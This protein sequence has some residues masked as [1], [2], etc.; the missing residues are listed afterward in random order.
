MAKG[1]LGKK[2]GMTQI[3]DEEGQAIPVTVIEAKPNVVVQ[4]KTVEI[5]GYNAIQIGFEDIKEHKLNKPLLGHFKKVGVSP[6]RYLKEIRTE[7]VEKYEVGQE[8]KVDIFKKGE[9]VDVVGTS[10][11]KGFA[12]A[13]KRWNFSRG[14]MSHG[15]RYH[16]RPGSLGSTDPARV[17]KGRKLPGRMGGERVTIRNLEIVKVDPEKNMLLIKGSVPGPKKG[18]VL[19]KNDD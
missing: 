5:D 3:F 10:K 19:I 7:D 15:S 8:I 12:G 1:I 18:L 16:R 2:I 13:I 11:G 17:F 14:P 9:K 6:K 4:K